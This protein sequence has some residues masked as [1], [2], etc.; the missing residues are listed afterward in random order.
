MSKE[1][2]KPEAQDLFRT[3]VSSPTSVSSNTKSSDLQ[4]ETPKKDPVM[5]TVRFQEETP[6]TDNE[7]IKHSWRGTSSHTESKLSISECIS[8]VRKNL[9][10]KKSKLKIVNRNKPS[11]RFLA[12]SI[13]KLIKPK[14]LKR[15]SS[16]KAKR[17][18]FKIMKKT[19]SGLLKSPEKSLSKI[20]QK[21]DLCSEKIFQATSKTYVEPLIMPVHKTSNKPF[22]KSTFSNPNTN[23]CSPARRLMDKLSK[24]KH[25]SRKNNL[26][27]LPVDFKG[28]RR[29]STICPKTTVPNCPCPPSIQNL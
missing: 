25:R 21:K 10:P 5:T 13:L 14:S 3:V 23:D 15:K 26:K 16:K 7:R 4:N 8:E 2:K 6:K 12:K 1:L 28:L 24:R 27:L 29:N 20:A 18:L 19:D 22:H 9:K 11:K 17:S